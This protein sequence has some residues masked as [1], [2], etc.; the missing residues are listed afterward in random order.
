M[1]TQTLGQ[2]LLNQHIPKQYQLKGTAGKKELRNKMNSL[3]RKDPVAYVKTITDLK[4]EGDQIATLEGLSVGLDDIAPDYRTRDTALKPYTTAFD[5][6][7]SDTQRRRIAEEAQDKMLSIATKHPGSMTQQVKS[8]ARGK[9]VQYMKIIASP[10]AARNPYGYTEPWLIRRSYSEG[11]KPS[12]YWVAGNEA[13]LDTIK[14]TVS[15]SEP[16]EL[17]KILMSNMADALITEIDCGTHNGIQMAVTDP[18]IIDRFLAKDTG[19]INRNTL[20]TSGIQS[21]L[22]KSRVSQILVRSPMTCESDDG[23]CQKCQGL[24]EKGNVHSLGVNVGVRAAS[25]MA[26]PLAQFALDAKHGVRTAKGD[27]ARLQGVAGFR[28]IIESPKQFM[29]KATLSTVGGIVSKIEKAPQG[30]TFVH[31]DKEKHFVAPTFGVVVKKGDSIEPGD[32][33]GEGIPKPDEVV[34]YKGLGAG[35]V[36]LVNTLRD[37]YTNQGKDLD[38]RHF[39]ILAKNELNHV[40]ILNDKNKTFIKGDVVSYN[41]LRSTLAQDSK[42]IDINESLG[43]ILGRPYFHFSAGQRI[44]PSV[45][46]YLKKAKVRTVMISSR[47]P[48]VEFIMKPASRAPLLHPDWMARLA[49]RNLKS[50]LQEAAHFGDISNLHGTHPVPAYAYGVDFGRGDEGRYRILFTRSMELQKK[51]L[52]YLSFCLEQ[53]NI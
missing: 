17:S 9:P 38:Q 32:R 47:A 23:I 1:T 26:E 6:A 3:A 8:G 10:A 44:T 51:H 29:N 19:R 11:L 35:R 46:N 18:N 28:Q 37:L 5:R 40:R 53:A 27:R 36:Y 45:L 13:I 42:E 43:E 30:G 41:K 24:D 48:D 31:V 33:L 25:A 22:R 21:Q 7:Q 50:T 15:V 4:R 49:H 12:D 14:S 39:E 16:G 34:K 20:I 52:R 2:L